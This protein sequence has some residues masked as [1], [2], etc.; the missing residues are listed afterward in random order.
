M[1]MFGLLIRWI[2]MT[3]GGGSMGRVRGK[4]IY[5][6]AVRGMFSNAIIVK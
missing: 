4:V 1:N 2:R 5:N 3:P 6:I